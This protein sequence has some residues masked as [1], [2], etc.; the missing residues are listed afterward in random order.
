MRWALFLL[1]AAGC[2]TTAARRDAGPSD[3]GA[4]PAEPAIPWIAAGRAP[5]EAPR[6]PWLEEGCP[7]VERPRLTPCAAGW[8]EVRSPEGLTWCDPTPEEG[9]P[10]C[11]ASEAFYV[12][13]EGC[14]PIGTPCSTAPFPE[15]PARAAVLYVRARA[16]SH[17][18]GSAPGA[19]LA[20]LG[21]ALAVA[22]DGAVIALG[23]GVYDE[24]VTIDRP[25]TILGTC[26]TGSVLTSSRPSETL[27][28][29]EVRAAGVVLR[30]L[31]LLDARR[32]AL[33]VAG[34]EASATVQGILLRGA[35][36]V[37]VIVEDGS[38]EAT[39]L[40]VRDVA[41]GNGVV[42]RGGRLSLSRSVVSRAADVGVEVIGGAAT[43][44]HVRVVA[45][46]VA[47]YAGGGVEASD[48]AQLTVTSSVLDANR[49]VGVVA[50][51]AGT[52]LD[53]G[54]VVVRDTTRTS[55]S[56]GLGVLVADGAE[57]RAERVV[58]IHDQAAEVGVVGAHLVATDLAA[59]EPW[60]AR[61][62]RTDIDQAGGVL[63]Q[64]YDGA[65]PA[66]ELARVWIEGATSFG[67]NT[68][69]GTIDLED[70]H[71]TRLQEWSPFPAN[72]RVANVEGA[73]R[74]VSIR[75]SEGFG[76][77]VSGPSRFTAEDLCVQD[78]RRLSREVASIGMGG[79]CD[80][81]VE[82]AVLE[83]SGGLSNLLVPEGE[84]ARLE[85][86]DVVMR[87]SRR[88]VDDLTDGPGLWT[89]DVDVLAE[90]VRFEGIPANGMEIA[91]A[92]LS[93][94]D[95]SIL[96]T[97]AELPRFLGAGVVLYEDVAA[98]LSRVDVAGNRT[99]GISA[100]SEDVTLDLEDV[101]IRDTRG[102]AET[103]ALGVGLW[104]SSHA[105]V[106]GRRV[107]VSG[108]RQ[109]GVVAEGRAEVVL[110]DLA[111]WDTLGPACGDACPALERGFGLL[112]MQR[113]SIDVSRFEIWSSAR[114][115]AL[116][117]PNGRIDLRAG[118]IVDAPIG[119]CLQ[120]E[121]YPL[122]RLRDGV[123][124]VDVG[125]EAEDTTLSLPSFEET[126][127]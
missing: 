90:R 10:A 62:E 84:R 3:G 105:R 72:V 22:P 14:E 16:P 35:T 91:H 4:T 97:E 89:E 74:R 106:T 61:S 37:G 121:G 43:L 95:V 25:V 11:S 127:P 92:T 17:G 70:V 9:V 41:A 103:D 30:D 73:A 53:L 112:A 83:G 45:N 40:V 71:V 56:D 49:H 102:A 104:A 65:A 88:T 101:S 82:R 27:A 126:Q 28:G 26:S 122:G 15:V 68:S 96:D 67:V 51:G 57:A 52:T 31:G 5:V 118:S 29:V 1:V 78:S 58:G 32:T 54:D 80:V 39:E 117:G 123:R 94:V 59:I 100:S 75:R 108:N 110:E 86:R 6:I 13:A 23:A 12:G 38:L 109:A 99:V 113:G 85:L 120:Q 64:P 7:P 42:V 8:R 63:G 93:L 66:I 47:P 44:S 114:C 2:G 116:V 79:A 87:A 77:G 21:E 34:A 50:A 60:R 107:V 36:G 81:R 115:G 76:V 48:G 125:A 98:T 111:V 20:T 55:S 69:E 18:D 124:F 46:G 119:L 19:P 24:D 33:R